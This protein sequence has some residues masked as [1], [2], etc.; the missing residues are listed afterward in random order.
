MSGKACRALTKDE[1][2]L[3]YQAFNGRYAARDRALFILGCYTGFR[4][5][6]LLSLR[7]GNFAQN[8]CN[9]GD[10][11]PLYKSLCGPSTEIKLKGEITV[12]E[13]K[14]GQTRTLKLTEQPKKILLLWLAEM[15]SLNLVSKSSYVFCKN[16]GD[17]LTYKQY[18]KILHN[19]FGNAGVTGR[20]ATHCMRKTFVANNL[21]I[22]NK[23][24]NPDEARNVLTDLKRLTGHASIDSL[25][26]YIPVEDSKVDKILSEYGNN[27]II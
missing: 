3:T 9:E 5:G 21:L 4:I 26:H 14:T 25:E 12:R 24:A 16:N 11:V 6:D 19:A 1:I 15:K 20:V 22:L 18:L 13:E 27:I 8:G 2:I 7:V 23:Y 10:E 17:K